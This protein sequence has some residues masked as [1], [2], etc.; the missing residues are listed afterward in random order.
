MIEVSLD[1]MILSEK[2][3]VHNYL[4]QTLGFPEHYGKNLDALYDCL[5]DLQD[6]E[7]KIH[8]S[9]QENVYLQ[10]IIRVFKDAAEENNKIKVQII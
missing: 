8:T 6:M 9:G 4:K 5:T 10:R 2:E 3:N 7:I 1:G